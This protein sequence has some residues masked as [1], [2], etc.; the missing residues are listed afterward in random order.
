MIRRVSKKNYICLLTQQC[1]VRRLKV[2]TDIP[3][4]TDVITRE[5]THVRNLT[6]EQI[7]NTVFGVI[8]LQ[9]SLILHS[10]IKGIYTE[11]FLRRS[12]TPRIKSIQRRLL[13]V[14]YFQIRR[15]AYCYP[16]TLYEKNRLPPTVLFSG[17]V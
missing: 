6:K 12:K 13:R 9:S 3:S 14:K 11:G 1:T 2:K 4:E 10:F 15:T 7:I 8:V 5:Y 16:V 17:F